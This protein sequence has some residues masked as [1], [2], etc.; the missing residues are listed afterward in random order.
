M[1]ISVDSF[2]KIGKSHTICEDYCISGKEPFPYVIL[3]DGCSS[4]KN[5]D[6][7]AR[8]LVHCAKDYL[9]KERS[10][11]DSIFFADSVRSQMGLLE[12]CLDVTL[13]ILYKKP[14]DKFININMYG[15]CSIISIVNEE[16]SGR[17]ISYSN[18]APYYLSYKLNNN[19]NKQYYKTAGKKE[20]IN[21]NPQFSIKHELYPC[22]FCKDRIFL[23]DNEKTAVIITTDGLSTFI[24]PKDGGTK[25]TEEVV[26]EL[27]NFKNT[28]GA[29]IQRRCNRM[30][31]EFEKEGYYHMD[32]FSVGGIYFNE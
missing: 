13:I 10:I 19:R 16:I 1:N 26:K 6:I 22:D 8:I 25:T 29:F 17:H 31:K 15:D 2:M 27:T 30:L 11:V 5:T 24:N 21:F 12:E 23:K 28:N 14:D 9:Q 32:D 18:N 20:L 3:A 7:G 4:S